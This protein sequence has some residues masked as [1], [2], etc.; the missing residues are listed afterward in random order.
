MVAIPQGVEVPSETKAPR[1][2]ALVVGSEEAKKQ[3]EV[4][5]TEVKKLMEKI[6]VASENRE[7]ASVTVADMLDQGRTG[8][9]TTKGVES[10][11]DEIISGGSSPAMKAIAG[12]RGSDQTYAHCTDMSTILED[13]YGKILIRMGKEVSDSVSRFTLLSGFMHA[14]LEAVCPRGERPYSCLIMSACELAT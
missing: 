2:P 9:F 10:M 4:K 5:V 8:N 14:V 12:L 6:E 1:A 7:K 11:V 13:C 3:H